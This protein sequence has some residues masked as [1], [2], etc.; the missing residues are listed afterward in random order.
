MSLDS[1]ADHWSSAV[2]ICCPI[3]KDHYLQS[4][5]HTNFYFSFAHLSIIKFLVCFF[6]VC[7]DIWISGYNPLPCSHRL[8]SPIEYPLSTALSVCKY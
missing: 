7:K 4:M 1:L 6:V 5:S 8:F 2:H 3:C